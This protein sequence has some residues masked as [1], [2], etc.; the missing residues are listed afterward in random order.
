MAKKERQTRQ[1]A[2]VNLVTVGPKDDVVAEV[3]GDLGGVG[4]APDPG[5]HRGVKQFRAVD[6]SLHAL[7]KPDG[8]LP[9][10]QQMRHRLAQPKVGRQR[11]RRKQIGQRDVRALGRALV[12]A[13]V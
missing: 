8:D 6:I 9:G 3:R 4:H 2:E 1:A 13:L 5:Q 7:R 11:K 10:P 12:L